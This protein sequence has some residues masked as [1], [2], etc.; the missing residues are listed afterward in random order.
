MVKMKKLVTI[1]ISF[2]LVSFYNPILLYA[3]N[4]HSADFE[5]DSSQYFSTA[6]SVD[7][8]VTGDISIGSWV[9]LES[10]GAS[11]QIVNKFNA[12]GNNRSYQLL[13][14]RTGDGLCEF[15]YNSVGTAGNTGS[16][17]TDA[18][19]VSGTGTWVH[20]AM[21]LDVSTSDGTWCVNGS[22]VASTPAGTQT[23]IF[24]GT[25]QMTIGAI[26]DGSGAFM[27]GLLDDVRIYNTVRTC[28]DWA[29]DYN[30]SL[31]GNETGLIAYYRFDNSSLE[32]RGDI[33]DPAG[34][35]ANDLTNNN[36]VT[37]VT[38]IP[39]GAAAAVIP[40]DSEII[41]FE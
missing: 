29:G 20:I 6:D 14:D 23:A 41:F 3:G 19:C 34:A 36:T 5:L 2:I 15:D 38:D 22:E 30:T 32:D 13:I 27:D 24:D 28:A 17:I 21:N 26:N 4:V 37:F 12:T 35:N 39:F 11:K 9:K 40:Q 7:I 18:A 8:S 25:S 10:S 1:L 31:N 33:T 16:L